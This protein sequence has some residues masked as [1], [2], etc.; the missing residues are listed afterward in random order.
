MPSADVASDVHCEVLEWDTT[1][2]GTVVAKVI[3]HTLTPANA[4]AIDDWCRRQRV[5]CVYFLARSDDA[6]TTEIAEHI[7]FHLTDIRQTFA[8]SA[9]ETCAAVQPPP[10]SA[11]VIRPFTVADLPALEAIARVSH[12]DTR[13]Y[14]DSRFSRER[15]GE[16]YATWI[17]V[18]CQD[19]RQQVLVAEIDG[20]ASGYVS[21]QLEPDGNGRIGLIG[22]ADH[23]RGRGIGGL[24]VDSA[25]TWFRAQAVP[26]VVVTTQARNIAAQRLY[27]RLCFKTTSVELWFHK[28]Y[29][30]GVA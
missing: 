8:W 29:D 24:L 12:T 25:L 19:P 20:S 17:R 26:A 1:F 22:V 11:A 10:G 14:F 23:A 3:G 21:C 7:G 6:A 5:S 30:T 2:W 28:W 16:L 13:F 18:S 15:C 4:A 27:Q 9:R